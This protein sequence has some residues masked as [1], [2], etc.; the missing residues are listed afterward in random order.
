MLL[1]VAALL[2]S[3]TFRYLEEGKRELLIRPG[4]AP[5]TQ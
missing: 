4:C 3:C 1:L 2:L 5:I